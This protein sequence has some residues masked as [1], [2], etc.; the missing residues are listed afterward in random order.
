RTCT[1]P[2]SANLSDVTILRPFRQRNHDRIFRHDAAQTEPDTLS[3]HDALPIYVRRRCCSNS[4][5]LIPMADSG[6]RISVST[7]ASGTPSSDRKSTR[8]NSSHVKISYAVFCLKQQQIHLPST[9][10]AIPTT[11]L[12]P[13]YTQNHL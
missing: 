8:L 11:R 13:R 6:L 3:L 7:R 4:P 5:S 2:A 1:S 12:N 9:R 10:Q